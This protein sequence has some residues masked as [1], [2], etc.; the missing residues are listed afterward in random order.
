VQLVADGEE[1]AEPV[2][3]ASGLDRPEGLALAP[4]GRLLVVETGADRLLAIDPATGDQE[5]LAEGLGFAL[6]NPVAAGTNVSLP[7]HFVFSGVAVSPSGDVYV[8]ADAANA[9][10]RIPLNP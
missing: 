7:P 4:D 6:A 3:V 2:T 1:L 8:S 10:Y 5:V 9:I